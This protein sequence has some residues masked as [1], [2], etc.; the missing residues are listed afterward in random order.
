MISRRIIEERKSAEAR[1]QNPKYLADNRGPLTKEER[2]SIGSVATNDVGRG[3][4]YLTARIAR[5]RLILRN[6]GISGTRWSGRV[7][8]PDRIEAPNFGSG[9]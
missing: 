6:E 5:D 9:V 8:P 4:D 2:E 1:A 3:A 7:A